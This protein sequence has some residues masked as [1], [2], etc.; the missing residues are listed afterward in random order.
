[1]TRVLI[2]DS[3]AVTRSI[4]KE[5]VQKSQNMEFAAEA[6]S[7]AEV[8]EKIK[9]GRIDALVIDISLFPRASINNAF[10]ECSKLHIP[11]LIFASPEDVNVPAPKGIA[12]ITKPKFTSISTSAMEAY[13]KYFVQTI[14]DL[15]QM[16]LF[17]SAGLKPLRKEETVSEKQTILEHIAFE[18]NYRAVLIGVSTGGPG[19]ILKLLKDIGKNFPLPIIITQHIDSQFDKNLITWLN[20]NCP[21]EVHL[22]EDKVAAVAGHVYFAPAD[23]HLTFMEKDGKNFY[24]TLNHDA[25][26]NFLRPSVDKM[27]ESGA[28]VFGAKTIAVL[29]TG[30]GN[31]G[32]KGCCLIKNKGGYTI[33]EAEETCVI[34][35]MPKAAYDMGGSREVLPL[36]RISERLKMLARAR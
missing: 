10:T 33:T 32:A 17:D 25:Q 23:Y 5:I 16:L 14:T 30:M 11:V 13:I 36:D 29:L 35:G 6:A 22:A 31:D 3:S 1:M 9:A 19:T 4:E 28:E 26:V 34:Y 15:K 7:F 20:N 12:V 8:Q 18:K 27:F 2:A 24:L 21:M